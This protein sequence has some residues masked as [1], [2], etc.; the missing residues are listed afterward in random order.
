MILILFKILGQNL[1]L[2]SE[3]LNK[4]LNEI[5]P[6]ILTVW[7][8]FARNSLKT[9]EY[10]FENYNASVWQHISQMTLNEDFIEEFQ[11]FVEL[12]L[13]SM[14]QNLSQY[15]ICEFQDRVVCSWMSVQ[16][17]LSENFVE[18]F[19]D[20]VHWASLCI[21]QNLSDHL[22]RQFSD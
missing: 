15:F 6:E 16:Q 12:G 22:M 20:K 11:N 4:T 2:G 21:S 13:F 10:K 3:L 7:Y 9:V 19:Q 17:R 5:S 8:F 18:E 1:V 14:K